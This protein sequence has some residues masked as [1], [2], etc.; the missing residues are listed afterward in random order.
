MNQTSGARRGPRA[1][2]IVPMLRPMHSSHGTDRKYRERDDE[3]SGT[4]ANRYYYTNN[5][6]SST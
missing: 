3:I 1:I 2:I 5:A 4:G 6:L